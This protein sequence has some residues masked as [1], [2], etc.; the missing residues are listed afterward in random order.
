MNENRLLN[1]LRDK[2]II[3]YVLTFF[4]LIFIWSNSL[5]HPTESYSKSSKVMEAVSSVMSRIF[6]SE[7]FLTVFF[8]SHVR[9]LAHFIEYMLLGAAVTGAMK[10]SHKTKLQHFYNSLSF[11]VIVAV[12]DEFIQIYTYRGSSVR[13]VVID[14]SGYF[15]G[16][17]FASFIITLV[18][19][20]KKRKNTNQA[21]Y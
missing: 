16:T 21:H 6:G 14:F 12:V 9:K 8:R 3:F 4:I 5:D 7:H 20:I 10:L 2:K 13:D 18:Y 11:S 15:S 1:R 19:I 17:V